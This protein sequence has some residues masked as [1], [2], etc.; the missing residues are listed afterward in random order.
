MQLF[1]M[2]VNKVSIRDVTFNEESFAYAEYDEDLVNKYLNLQGTK[3]DVHQIAKFAAWANNLQ[4]LKHLIDDNLI[5]ELWVLHCGLAAKNVEV[6]KLSGKPVSMHKAMQ[7]DSA[8]IVEYAATHMDKIHTPYVYSVPARKGRLD[9]IKRLEKSIPLDRSS[10]FVEAVRGGC[11][12]TIKYLYPGNVPDEAI[13]A[14]ADHS[15]TEILKWLLSKC[16]SPDPHVLKVT[17]SNAFRNGNVNV[18][19]YIHA[20]RRKHKAND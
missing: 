3:A 20:Y 11:L 1:N 7:S 9:V 13:K 18:A 10:V 17:G 4:L 5:E 14:T 6:V 15:R 8:D 12:D 2:P 16:D 19:Q